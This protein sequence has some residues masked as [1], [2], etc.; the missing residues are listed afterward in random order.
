MG[1]SWNAVEDKIARN[2]IVNVFVF[3]VLTELS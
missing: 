3:F 2:A 1:A